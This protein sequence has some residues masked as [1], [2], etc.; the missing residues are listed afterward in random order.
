MPKNNFF[1]N[2]PYSKYVGH[3]FSHRY[4]DGKKMSASDS[5]TMEWNAETGVASLVFKSLSGNMS[6][7][8]ECVAT[9]SVGTAKSATNVKVKSKYICMNN[10]L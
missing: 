4:K 2:F 1:I 5:L 8:Y 10:S 3:Y 7:S 6:G 9:S